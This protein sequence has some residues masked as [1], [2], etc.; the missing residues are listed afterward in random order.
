MSFGMKQEYDVAILGAG[1]AGMTAALYAARGGAGV[2]LLDRIGCG[3]QMAGISEIENYPGFPFVSGA[4][5]TAYMREQLLSAGAELVTG[6]AEAVRRQ[7]EGF[8]LSASG[9]REFFAS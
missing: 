7:G 5:L 9:E 6:E 2:L 1:P 8:M 4:E 3:G